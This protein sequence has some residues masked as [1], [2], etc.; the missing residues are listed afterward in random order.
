MI[1]CK[2]AES[3]RDALVRVTE[4]LH[5]KLDSLEFDRSAA[6]DWLAPEHFLEDIRILYRCPLDLIN[7][8]SIERA[9]TEA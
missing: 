7:S 4:L 5:L 3:D 2:D 6:F 1:I 9:E 8:L